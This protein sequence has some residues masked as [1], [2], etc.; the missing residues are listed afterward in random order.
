VGAKGLMSD[1]SVQGESSGPDPRATRRLLVRTARN[2]QPWL[3]LVALAALLM[4]AADTAL[5]AILGRS[6]DSILHR[7]PPLWI[8]LSAVGVVALIAADALDDLATGYAVA[9]STSW[10]R[11]SLLR[12]FL[13]LGTRGGRFSSGDLS[14][15]LAA[16]AAEAGQVGPSLVRGMANVL[17]GLGAVVALGLIDPWLC[18]TFLAGVP[19]LALTLRAFARQASVTAEGYLEAQGKIAARLVDAV[20][21]ARTIAAAGTLEQEIDRVLGPLPE[22]RRHGADLWRQLA[23]F[24][25][26]D[27]LLPPMLGI[28]VLAV[29]GSELSR[30]RITP[31]AMLA[32]AEYAMLGTALTSLTSVVQRVAQAR[33]AAGR[34]AEV[35]DEPPMEYGDAELPEGGGCI[36]FRGVS[37]RAGGQAVLEVDHLLIPGGRLIAVVGRSGSGKSL[38]AHLAGR[39]IDSEEG[40]VTLDGVPL[41]RLRRDVLRGAVTYAFERPSLFGQTLGEAI[42]FGP[43]PS[44]AEEVASAACTAQAD[45]FIRR[46]PRAY[47]TPLAEAPMSGGEVQRISLAR[48][49]AHA[50][51]VLILDDVA[52]SLDTVTEH[53][54]SRVLNEDLGRLTRLVVAHRASTAAR[55]DAVVWLDRGRIRATGPHEVLWHDPDYRALFLGTSTEPTEAADGGGEG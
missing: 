2:G 8:L 55:A 1:N 45:G 21:G 51:R 29:A 38:L 30:G 25:S 17:T 28:V 31:G 50:G 33:A 10:L 39:L 52:A 35:L 54:I 7:A 3:G 26:L 24:G 18:L 53:E 6:V 42:S 43:R 32:A 27:A 44:S 4:A 16:N 13:A 14:G 22:L 48:A 23:R 37:V 36:E 15:R 47:D 9:G 19:V 49:F 41:R 40:D 12:H 46:M 5:P 20:S 34:C 11:R